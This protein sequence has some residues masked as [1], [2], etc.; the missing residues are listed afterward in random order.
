[1]KRLANAGSPKNF[2]PAVS[3]DWVL[4]VPAEHAAISFHHISTVFF[5]EPELLDGIAAI[6]LL[7]KWVDV[8]RRHLHETVD[9]CFPEVEKAAEIHK[10]YVDQTATDIDNDK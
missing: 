2:I 6:V 8:I 9:T 5:S 10:Y 4:H 1:M 3:S 7:G